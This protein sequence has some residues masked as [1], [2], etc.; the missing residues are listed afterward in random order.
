MNWNTLNYAVEIA[1]QKSFS[2]AAQALY[3]AQPSLSQSIQ[4]LERELGTPIFDRSKSPVKLTYAGELFVEWARQTL[5][6]REQTFKQ[7]ADTAEGAK[8]RLV[9]GVGFSRSAFLF[10]NII[11]EFRKLRPNCTVILEENT[12]NLLSENDEL[13]LLIDVPHDE[14][15]INDSII[16][17]EE[18]MLLAVPENFE[19]IAEQREDDVPVLKLSDYSNHPF[20]MLSDGQML[21]NV[22]LSLCSQEGFAPQTAVECRSLQTAYSM[23]E[24]GIGVTIVP[25]LV[26]RHT[27]SSHKLHFGVIGEIPLIRKIAVTYRKD[28]YLSEDAKV[29]IELM[30]EM[31]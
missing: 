1:K 2:K 22:C 28:R 6:T 29:L 10:P 23:A 11:A 27:L 5:L 16:I 15:L 18:R 24:A 25:E 12:T 13:D 30:Q 8:T 31:L 17:A 9:V 3:I 26:V 14:S 21:R 4:A 7:I 19:F 20:V